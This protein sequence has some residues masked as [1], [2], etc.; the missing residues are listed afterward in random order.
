MTLGSKPIENGVFFARLAQRI[1]HILNTPTSLGRLF[2]VDTRLR[3]NGASGLLVSGIDA[4][5][6]Y[7]KNEA[8]T[9]E[10]QALTRARVVVGDSVIAGLFQ[11]VR[12]EVLTRKRDPDALRKEVREMREKMREQLGSHSKTEFGLKQDSGGIADIEFIVQY[13]VL[14]YASEYPDLIEFTD[15]IRQIEALHRNAIIRENDANLLTYAYQAYRSR[16]HRLAL[17][18]Q[19][20]R[21]PKQ[22][23]TAY[24][25]GIGRL[26]TVWMEK[27]GLG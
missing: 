9:W 8:W 12:H 11:T 7:Q 27:G 24:Q 5:A 22:D 16:L 2:E 4:F 20:A 10:H 21:I 19:P 14:R 13:A 15:N 23:F 25:Q 3:P 6:N 18:E 1:I 26:W 17:Q